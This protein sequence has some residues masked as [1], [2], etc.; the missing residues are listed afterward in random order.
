MLTRRGIKA[1]LY[2]CRTFITMRSL[3]NIKEVQQLIGRL[4]ALF[5][6]VSR[7]GGKAFLFFAILK[8][9]ERFEW[10]FEC[11]EAFS[12]VKDFLVL[13]PILTRLLEELLLLYLSVLYQAMRSDLVQE[14]EKEKKPVYFILKVFRGLEVRYWKIKKLALVVIVTTRKLKPYFQGHKI[15]V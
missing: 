12:K 15:F 1:S 11:E 8:K 3:T 13:P 14:I 10:T 4:V 2:K 5:H 6:F 9:K 7:A